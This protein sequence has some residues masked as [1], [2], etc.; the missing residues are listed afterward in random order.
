MGGLSLLHRL[1]AGFT[2]A[3][4]TPVL[5]PVASLSLYEWPGLSCVPFR[6]DSSAVI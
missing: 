4:G 6:E 1:R 2:H 5:L 3:F